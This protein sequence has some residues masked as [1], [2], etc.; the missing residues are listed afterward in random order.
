MTIAPINVAASCEV[1]G[2][3]IVFWVI[4]IPVLRHTKSFGWCPLISWVTGRS[5]GRKLQPVVWLVFDLETLV[6]AAFLRNCNAFCNVRLTNPGYPPRKWCIRH[7][8]SKLTATLCLCESLRGQAARV[9]SYPFG[10]HVNPRKRMTLN[11]K[12]LPKQ[13]QTKWRPFFPGPC[14]SLRRF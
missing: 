3:G 4:D 10:F 7:L 1:G 13:L 9:E 5:F 14:G 11:K 6:F 12:T 8:Q 2:W